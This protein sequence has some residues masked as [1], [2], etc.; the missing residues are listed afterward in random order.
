MAPGQGPA[1]HSGAATRR[2]HTALQVATR[3][4]THPRARHARP[5][6][7]SSGRQL[8]WRAGLRLWRRRRR[9]LQPARHGP[10]GMVEIKH[11]LSPGWGRPPHPADGL[12]RRRQHALLRL[13]EA[14]RLRHP[15]RQQHRAAL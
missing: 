9:L 15:S 4:Q 14:P 13:R 3:A 5:R 12:R 2:R 7:P 6:S 8:P 1:A 10:R 11:R